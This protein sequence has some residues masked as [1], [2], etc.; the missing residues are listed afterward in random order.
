MFFL[1][2]LTFIG[3]TNDSESVLRLETNIWPGYEPLNL[4]RH[5]GELKKNIHLVELASHL[6]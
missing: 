5:R 6:R 1:I 4:A 2:P 3:C